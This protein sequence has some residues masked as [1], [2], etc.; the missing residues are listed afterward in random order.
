MG[1]LRVLGERTIGFAD[2]RGNRQYV[3]VGNLADDNRVA[4]FLMDYPRRARLKLLGRAKAVSL[5]EVPEL[6]TALI[7]QSYGAKVER[8]ILIELEAFDWNCSQHITERFT[9]AE[10][11]PAIAA[12]RS[13]VAEL[14]AELASV[15]AEPRRDDGSRAAG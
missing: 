6:G 13:R 15:R 5:S 7:D 11:E 10:I 4:L 9:K 12:L 1:F 2:F 8:A 3:S 14:E